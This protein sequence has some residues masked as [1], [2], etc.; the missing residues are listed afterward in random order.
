MS[1]GE[2]A[3]ELIALETERC[4][5]MWPVS[6]SSMPPEIPWRPSPAVPA[7]KRPPSASGAATLA[8]GLERQQA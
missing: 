8:A 2:G 4:R 6:R 1:H 3:A 5:A 7:A